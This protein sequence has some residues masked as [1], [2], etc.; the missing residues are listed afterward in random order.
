[1]AVALGA[2]MERRVEKLRASMA[3][4]YSAVVWRMDS[5]AV[6]SAMEMGLERG[7]EARKVGLI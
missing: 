2:K 6:M 4:A 5:M 1:L 7:D 3:R